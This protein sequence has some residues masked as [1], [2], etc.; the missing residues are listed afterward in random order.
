LL[1][2]IV[3]FLNVIL[4]FNFYF[5]RKE[6]F[7][8]K[9]LLTAA[10]STLAALSLNS[11]CV[12]PVAAAS[13]CCAAGDDECVAE[14]AE[15]QINLSGL[16]FRRCKWV[17]DVEEAWQ[18]SVCDWKLKLDCIFDGKLMK[19]INLA[20]S[21]TS[22][23][24]QE[25]ISLPVQDSL[26]NPKNSTL[27]L[28]VEEKSIEGDEVPCSCPG[29]VS[30]FWLT[31]LKK[32]KTPQDFEVEK[33]M[34]EGASYGSADDFDLNVE[35]AADE[36]GTVVFSVRPLQHPAVEVINSATM[37]AIDYG[38]VC[39]TK[40]F[41]SVSVKESGNFVFGYLVVVD[42]ELV[43]VVESEMESGDFLV[44]SFCPSPEVRREVSLKNN[45]G[46]GIFPMVAL[47]KKKSEEKKRPY[48]VMGDR[49]Q[50]KR[51]HKITNPFFT[52]VPDVRE[53]EKFQR[54]IGR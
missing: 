28:T 26:G 17:A 51:K 32:G 18:P 13:A 42:S 12:V 24:S 31:D 25:V 36:K 4:I 2:L 20:L 1:L 7:M 35:A 3:F 8:N 52:L 53:K 6:K 46:N 10:A 34:W 33:V 49:P 43:F 54:G 15:Q 21:L 30:R 29:Y 9:T 47:D 23:G 16:D 39:A 27:I 45:N 44:A 48:S 37:T 41:P 14:I 38:S 11:V 22:S 5:R 40:V 19:E 50:E